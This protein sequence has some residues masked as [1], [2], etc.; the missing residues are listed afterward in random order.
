MFYFWGLLA[1]SIVVLVH[2]WGHFVVARYFKIKVEE[3]GLGYPPKI[4]SWKKNGVTYSLNAIPFGGFNKI[5]EDKKETN[6]F[7]NKSRKVR[8]LVLVAGSFSNII[9]AVLIFSFLFATAMP[10]FLLAPSLQ[11]TVFGHVPSEPYIKV[12]VYQAP[13]AAAEFTARLT[14]A[15]LIGT[16][17]ALK[18]LILQGNYKELVGPVGLIAI[19]SSGFHKGFSV[20]LFMIGLISLALAIFNL[21][22]IPVA[23]GGKLLILLIEKIRKKEIPAKTQLLIDNICLALLILLAILV[24]AKDIKFFFFLHK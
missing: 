11:R 20:G 12:P 1:L 15:L 17:Q 4:F 21:L 23:D 18:N 2:E 24:T 7:V 14:S 10:T 13:L 9:L 16:G 22:P 8:A 3:F 6:S 5:C 19:T